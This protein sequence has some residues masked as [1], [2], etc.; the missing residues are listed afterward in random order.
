MRILNG[1]CMEFKPAR[2]QFKTPGVVG[3]ERAPLSDRNFELGPVDPD[4]SCVHVL[5]DDVLLR[6][7]EYLPLKKLVNIERGK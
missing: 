7:F 4:Q 3:F 5:I 2:K 1:N 6:I